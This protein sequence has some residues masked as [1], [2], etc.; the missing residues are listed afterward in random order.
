MEK[1]ICTYCKKEF[2]PCADGRSHD[3]CSFNCYKLNRIE[4]HKKDA[5]YRAELGLEPSRF[6]TTRNKIY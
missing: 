6:C 5:A 4:M 2:I 3:L 1:K